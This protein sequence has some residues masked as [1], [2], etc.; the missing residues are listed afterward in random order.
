MLESL[1]LP[2][3]DP[4]LIVAIVML[5]ILI[6]PIVFKRLKIPGIV[7]IIVSGTIVGPSV[8]G[9][10]ERDAT[11]ILLGTVGLLYLM[12]MAGLSIDLNQFNRLKHKSI[13]FG[14]ISFSLPLALAF[15]LAPYLLDYPIP[16]ALLLGSIVGSHTL[17]AYP[18]AH[19]LGIT[20]NSAV[21]MTMGGT[22]VTDTLS[23]AILALVVGSMKDGLTVSF[24]TTFG[25]S[26][27]IFVTASILILPRLGRWF[28]KTFPKENDA[29]YVFLLA[30]M[31]V[32]AWF[33]NIAGLAPIIG[34]FL[35]GLL[36]NRLVPDSSPLM[37]KV[38]FVGNALF[39]PFFLISVGMLVDVSV[40]ISLDVWVIALL[41]TGMV[42]VGKFI[43]A[44]VSKLIFK[45]TNAE[46][47]T[48]FGLSTPQAAA[49][50]A[51]TLIGF[52]VGL[53]NE[54]AV[55]GVVIMILITCLIGPY[56]VEKYGR[57]IATAESGKEYNKSEAPQRILVPLANPT[58]AEALLDIAFAM[59]DVNS[60]ESV[61]PLSVVR[62][63]SNVQAQVAESEKMLSHAVVY[64]SGAEI[65]V[66][67]VTRVDMN[68]SS[69]INRAI[70]EKRITTVIIGW[71]GESSARQRI[72]GG[73]LD[74]LL[75]QTT[76]MIMV[77][78]IEEKVNTNDQVI[79][80]IP[81][82]ASLEPGFLEAIRSIKILANQ[83]G[84]NIKVIAVHDRIKILK[85]Y[86]DK[87]VPSVSTEYIDI[88]NWLKLIEK[89]DETLDK[90][91][92]FILLSAREGTISWRAGLDRMPG[93]IANRFSKNN[94]ITIFPSETS[95]E[96]IEIDNFNILDSIQ[97]N[98]ISIKV[99][100]QSVKELMNSVL[101][102]HF[103]DESI[104]HSEVASSLLEN[105][106]DYTPE[107]IPGVAIFDA[108]TSQVNKS[109]IL[110][111]IENEGIKIKKSSV[112]IKLLI[113]VINPDT[114]GAE[115]HFNRL[116]EVAKVFKNEK[117]VQSII[118]KSDAKV[119]MKLLNDFIKKPTTL[120]II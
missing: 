74:Q 52:D 49:T 68:I 6:S 39:I 85:N 111:I 5:I 29:D 17:L 37:T 117:L 83:I 21:T 115:G 32:N 73:V 107:I 9:L 81:P 89:L 58:T 42:I 71:N 59:R 22:M 72:F 2:V 78:K 30:I 48:I 63:G 47:F 15:F 87:I 99:G 67:P 13:I 98:S 23:L 28:F 76:E 50:L 3:H 64:A 101:K 38:Q 96:K 114:C 119:V 109:H 105:T 100:N 103:D 70:K 25:I 33:A 10:L 51:V 92:L 86:I 19:R 20:K 110:L 11:I 46:G 88:P 40:L 54:L 57:T 4:V 45:L 34:A 69:G 93:L 61:Y 7:G 79:L 80:A 12:F 66:S 31:F 43:A 55:N 82:L 60:E 106:H 62:D 16:T 97:E 120:D 8:T 104:R 116:N 95:S 90:N 18:I 24:L 112:P 91:S 27:G 14:V 84:T 41:F 26:V 44:W 56:I 75:E 1:D 35:A 108:H 113:I 118:S 94:F 36:L 53:F 77:S 65:P 102:K